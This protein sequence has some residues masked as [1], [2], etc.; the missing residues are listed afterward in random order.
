MTPTMRHAVV[1]WRYLTAC[2]DRH[3]D[4]LLV[5]CGSYDLRVCDYACDLFHRGRFD[6]LLI[7]GRTGNWT[8]RLWSEREAQ[9]FAKRAREHGISD[10]SM[11]L[12]MEAT[13]M[14]ENIRNARRLVPTADKVTFVTKLNSIRR[15]VA[16]APVQWPDADVR[17]DGLPITFPDEVSNI[18]GLFGLMSEMVGDIDRLIKYPALGFQV[19]SDVPHDVRASYLYLA[20]HGFGGHMIPSVT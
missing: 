16:T 3:Q 12:E 9:V 13:N 1:L 18:V 17:V 10:A 19:A 14:A 4:G 5:I 7:T 2:P 15:V 11:T 6:R 8:D 20:E